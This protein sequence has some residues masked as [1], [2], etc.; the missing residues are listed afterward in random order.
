M[1]VLYL[2]VDLTSIF[3]KYS[4]K[5][6]GKD[7][8]LIVSVHHTSLAVITEFNSTLK[9][10]QLKTKHPQIFYFVCQFKITEVDYEKSIKSLKK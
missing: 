3:F 4:L 8:I 1:I 9:S 2:L 6:L 10:N 5:V 7:I